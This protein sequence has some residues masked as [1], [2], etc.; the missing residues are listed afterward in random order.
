MDKADKKSKNEKINLPEVNVS[1]AD[2]EAASGASDA[3][4]LEVRSHEELEYPVIT[5]FLHLYSNLSALADTQIREIEGFFQPSSAYLNMTR[6]H[7][8]E[9]IEILIINN[10]E[11][12]FK[13]GEEQVTLKPGQGIFINQN[14]LHTISPHGEDDCSLYSLVFHP[15]FLFGYG[16]PGLSAKYLTPVL[17]SP[18]LK[19][20]LLED[21]TESIGLMLNLINDAIAYN[22]A[23]RFGYELRVKGCLCEF[24]Y[25]LLEYAAPSQ[26][27]SPAPRPGSMTT[28]AMRV[29]QAIR[30]IEEKYTEQVT[31]DDISAAIH[32]SK[33]E[34]CRCFKRTLGL[35][36]FEYLLK[37]RIYESTRLMRLEDSELNSIADL[38]AAVGF[39][40]TSYYN[41]LFKKYLSCTPL[42]YK[43]QLLTASRLQTPVNPADAKYFNK[44][45]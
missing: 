10:G 43:R 35:T 12:V 26:S 44:L 7:W 17:S 20:L 23:K 5:Q 11:A 34:C 2:K 27:F 41:K 16:H 18:A 45:L 15:A 6:W 37:F 14:V 40:S 38:A 29:K 42:E 8:H 25:L 24:W 21:N 39:N 33:S 31:L 3:T 19:Y 22:M 13:T 36:P 1:A 4:L 9:E 28:D 30:F 32:I